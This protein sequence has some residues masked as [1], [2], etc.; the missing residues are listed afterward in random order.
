[1][2]NNKQNE[3][4]KGSSIEINAATEQNAVVNEDNSVEIKSPIDFVKKPWWES[5][6]EHSVKI[7]NLNYME[8]Y[9]YI[10]DEK[11]ALPP[12]SKFLIEKYGMIL[13]VCFNNEKLKF[14]KL[15]NFIIKEA[16]TVKYIYNDKSRN[17]D[18]VYYVITLEDNKGY[19]NINIEIEGNAKSDYLKFQE[20]L[21][22]A[23]NN[24]QIMCTQREFKTL[25]EKFIQP[26]LNSKVI[27]VYE[28]CGKIKP[29]T[30]LGG[31]FLIENGNIY[32]V[33]EDGLIPTSQENVF[34]KVNDK[35]AFKLPKL[36]SSSKSAQVIAKDFIQNIVDSWGINYHQALLVIGHM[37]MGLYF[38]RFVT[39]TMGVPVLIIAGISGCGKSTLVQ[40]GISIFGLSEDFLIAGNSTVLGQNFISSSINGVN[41]CVD[42]LSD[43]T[44][45]SESFGDSMK[46][47]FKA[48][49]RVKRTNFGKNVHME[50]SC[51]QIV[52]STNSALPEIPELENRANLITMVNNS[53]DTD[54][55]QYLS[56]HRENTEELSLLLPELLK[57]DEDYVMALH[58]ELKNE[59]KSSAEDNVMAR[60][61]HNIAYMWT[62][63]TLLCEIAGVE[64][65][66]IKEDII[67][68]TNE[69]IEHYK[70]IPSPVDILINGLLTLKNH[71]A[72]IENQHYKIR[73]DNDRIYLYFHKDTLLEA[74]NKFFKDSDR[75][76]RRNIFNNYLKFDK[77][78]IDNSHT[79]NYGGNR[80]NSIVLDITDN[81]DCW[82]FS[83][84]PEPIK[85]DNNSNNDVSNIS[86]ILYPNNKD[87]T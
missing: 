80:K 87:I 79:M 73:K 78:I 44:L 35:R 65:K 82:E 4:I 66:N 21:N 5:L 26:K 71:N 85:T 68:F 18:Y 61:P 77:R 8:E 51:S 56:E 72:I 46:R 28:N 31:D 45:T 13:S 74:Y 41:I 59:I 37:V 20:T 3:Q 60:I 38:D 23:D 32:R 7:S 40:N 33:N 52:Y 36:S 34:I 81:S 70:S 16:S 47:L 76:I 57:F 84:Y 19:K 63:L 83:G 55:Y 27:L 50:Y 6:D 53:L 29:N 62:G 30:F 43:R 22:F 9:S 17:K 58:N 11:Y 54:K 64:L 48:I 12:K 14:R 1:M 39:P 69:S 49:P 75:K 15:T 25:F 86:D 10:F 24:F 67:K 2:E 42:D